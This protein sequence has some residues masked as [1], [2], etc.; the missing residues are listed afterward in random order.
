MKFRRKNLAFSISRALFCGAFAMGGLL[1][2]ASAAD[3]AADTAT[4]P[5]PAA[6]AATSV[7]SSD[8][9]SIGVIT[10]TAQAR[11]QQSQAVPISM[12]LINAD[13][14]DKLA[15]TNM[16]DLN[17]YI[18]GLVVDADQPTQPN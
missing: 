14:I 11:S 15:A 16:G 6:P 18:P 2:Q 13:Q 1:D 3:P 7:S 9:T 10:V 4:T 17:G 8:D 5:T 12:Q